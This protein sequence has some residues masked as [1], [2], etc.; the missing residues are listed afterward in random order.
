M[1]VSVSRCESDKK[2]I[3][4]VV[5]FRMFFQTVSQCYSVPMLHVGHE[6]I[7]VQL[8][9]L[10]VHV[11]RVHPI[12]EQAQPKHPEATI[13]VTRRRVHL[14]RNFNELALLYRERERVMRPLL[15]RAR[16][17]S[18]IEDSALMLSH[19]QPIALASAVIQRMPR[20]F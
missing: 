7:A 19:R 11:F 9:P 8:D 18:V 4:Q 14:T 10:D 13:I 3:T 17:C 20:P 6:Q 2:N 12:L 15:H 16:S 5:C 1:S